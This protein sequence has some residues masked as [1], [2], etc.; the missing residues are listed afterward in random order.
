MTYQNISTE[1][2]KSLIGKEDHILIDVRAP[3]EYIEGKIEG[4][5]LINF[6]EPDFPEQIDKLDR[7]KNYLVYCRSGNR[8]GQTCQLM[9]S[10]GFKGELYNLE[11]GIQ[12]WNATYGK[13]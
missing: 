8:S 11:G 7:S 1:T 2:F 9:Q 12:A 3:E 10:M 5:Q 13:L 4:H 6:K